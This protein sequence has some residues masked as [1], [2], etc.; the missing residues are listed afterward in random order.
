TASP[1]LS[2]KI[3]PKTHLAP[4]PVCGRP[5]TPLERVADEFG[6]VVQTKRCG[7]AADLDQLIERA[8]DSLGRQARVNLDP[9][10]LAV[11]V[12]DH[13]E[14]AKAPSRPQRIG[15]EGGRPDLVRAHQDR[16][17]CLHPCRQPSLAPALQIEPE[18]LVHAIQSAFAKAL[19]RS[20]GYSLSK[21]C[22]GF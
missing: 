2:G 12:V 9:E 4:G 1:S 15:H 14:D 19:S 5:L 22:R 10:H 20:A 8:N 18:R 13:V 6:P 16:Q 7:L 11:K 17:R 3:L 21:P